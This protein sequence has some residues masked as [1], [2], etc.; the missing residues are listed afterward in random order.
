V[1]NTYY[2][3][4]VLGFGDMEETVRSLERPRRPLLLIDEKPSRS[5][6]KGTAFLFGK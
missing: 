1:K 5:P 2:G 6:K 3:G 4:E